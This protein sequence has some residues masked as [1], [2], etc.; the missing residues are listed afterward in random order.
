MT[1]IWRRQASGRIQAK[2]LIRDRTIDP[3]VLVTAAFF[4]PASAP[5][6]VTLN[7]SLHFGM[8]LGMGLR[9]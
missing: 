7:T 8:E 2:D 6:R 3:V 1:S 5:G 4:E 9:M